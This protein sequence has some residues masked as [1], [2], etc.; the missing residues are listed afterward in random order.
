V[1]ELPF[2]IIGPLVLGAVVYFLAG[3]RAGPEHFFAFLGII[4]LESLAAV[5]LGMAIRWVGGV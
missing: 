5:A 2:N 3:L 4:T 1:S